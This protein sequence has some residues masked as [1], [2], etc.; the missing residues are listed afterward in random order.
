MRV[1]RK[2]VLAAFLLVPIVLVGATVLVSVAVFGYSLNPDKAQL[3]LADI[4]RFEAARH[5]LRTVRDSTAF[6][7]TAYFEPGTAGLRQYARMYRRDG[8]RLVRTLRARPDYYDSIA[9]VESRIRAQFPAIRAAFRTF[10]HRYGPAVFPPTYFVIGARG[11]GGANGFRGVYISA[12]TYG[13]RDDGSPERPGFYRTS[14]VPHLVTH[15]LVH[16]N[17]AIRSP[18]AYAGDQTNLARAI[19]E[20]TADFM[21][22]LVSGKHINPRAHAFGS[23]YE[24]QLWARF[25]RDLLSTDP[26]EWFFVPPADSVTPQ[27]MG[28]YLGFRI[29]QSWYERHRSDPDVISRLM[30]TD[31]YGKF[32]RESGYPV[33]G[34]PPRENISKQ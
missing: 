22:Q 11:P 32:F 3:V 28:Y 4:S 8:A 18:R 31:D 19:R 16:F 5:K 7:D 23:R 25:E 26:G 6:L 34:V 17:Q 33:V 1:R 20:G 14:M 13:A 9:D 15:E 10:K 27:D 30:G 24:A 29:V 12:D 2:W 21:A